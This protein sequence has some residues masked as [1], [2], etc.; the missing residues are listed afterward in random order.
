MPFAYL[1]YNLLLQ[2]GMTMILTALTYMLICDF[3]MKITRTDWFIIAW[4]TSL[5]LD[6]TKQVKT[7]QSFHSLAQCILLVRF[8]CLIIYRRLLNFCD[9]PRPSTVVTV[10][11]IRQMLLLAHACHFALFCSQYT[12]RFILIFFTI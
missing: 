10:W 6:E 7:H 2:F 11:S 4:M 5:F 3:S 12:S 9:R 1:S 8:V